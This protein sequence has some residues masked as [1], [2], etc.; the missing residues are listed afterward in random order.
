MI[1]KNSIFV[2]A[3]ILFGLFV[4]ALPASAQDNPFDIQFPIAELGD[5]ASIDECRDYCD[6][7]GNLN[8]CFDWAESQ[9]IAVERPHDEEGFVENGPG[10]CTTPEECHNYCED[11][12]NREEC[13]NFAVR[14]GHMS[15]EEAD[16]ILRGGPGGCQSERECDSYCRNPEH[17][18][19]CLDFAVSEGFLTAEEA[20]QIGRQFRGDFDRDFGPG[21]IGHDDFDDDFDINKERVLALLA[22]QGGPGG[23]ASFDECEAYCNDPSNDE[24]CFDFAIEHDL[25]QGDREDIEKF[26]RI[27]DAEGPGGCRGFECR[28]YC[29]EPGHESECLDFAQQHGLITAEEA[30]RI[31]GFMQATLDGGP[32]GCRGRA[33]EEY[34]NSP[35]HREECFAFA[36]DNNLLSPEEIAEIEKFRD[37]EKKIAN[38]GGP[39]G[40]RSERECRNYCSDTSH[41]DECAA[42]AVQEGFLD[43]EE[44]ERGLRRFIEIEEFGA[45]DFR[46][47]DFGPGGLHDDFGNVP[48][49][50]REQ[51]EREFELRR[52]DFERFEREFEGRDFPEHDGF[53][54]E[55][56]DERSLFDDGGIRFD[57]PREFGAFEDTKAFIEEQRRGEIEQLEYLKEL[58]LQGI[59]PEGDILERFDQFIGD[60][61]FEPQ[62]YPYQ[63]PYR[64]EEE[65][66][67][68]GDALKSFL[69][70]QLDGALVPSPYGEYEIIIDE[71]LLLNR[72]DGTIQIIVKKKSSGFMDNVA[73]LLSGL[74]VR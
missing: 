55:R 64:Q 49:E 40:C 58:E 1:M 57:E 69:Y 10:G 12:R 20:E 28:E 70:E 37:V 14:E 23:C 8:A 34:C 43:P 5:C 73:N 19:E 47:G 63:E 17:G 50:F 59:S 9:G 60:G 51:F 48:P 21:Q 22:E 52:G 41:F 54:E 35:D 6:D 18:E 15:Q 68:E 4:V 31:Q 44:A 72:Y 62:E 66:F 30:Q 42:F 2:F 27:R 16:R 45:G 13:V 7:P 26:K 67:P 3:G 25:F 46:R 74:S 29:D 24:E 65:S 56:F 11:E 38:E 33:C 53:V 71:G 32:G 61:N 36:T 39:G